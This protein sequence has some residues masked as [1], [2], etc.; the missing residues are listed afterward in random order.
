[1]NSFTF[2]THIRLDWQT[3]RST[4]QFGSGSTTQSSSEWS[5]GT[6]VSKIVAWYDS[7]KYFCLVYSNLG[8]GFASGCIIIIVEIIYVKLTRSRRNLQCRCGTILFLLTL[9]A[10]LTT[11]TVLM[12]KAYHYPLYYLIQ[13][14]QYYNPIVDYQLK[15]GK[16]CERI[17]IFTQFIL[18]LTRTTLFCTFVLSCARFGSESKTKK[19]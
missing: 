15:S 6:F 3:K 9:S 7:L 10:I 19:P 1:M 17:N 12:I 4:S 8:L 14:I 13:E 5:I 11:F 2:F 16:G 18:S